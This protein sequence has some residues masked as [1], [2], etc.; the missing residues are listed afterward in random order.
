[1]HCN[2]QNVLYLH[3][4]L[5][6]T[7]CIYAVLVVQYAV[8]YSVLSTARRKTISTS[9]GRIEGSIYLSYFTL[10]YLYPCNRTQYKYSLYGGTSVLSKS[11]SVLIN[12]VPSSLVYRA[13]YK[14][15]VADLHTQSILILI[16][17]RQTDEA[18]VA[19]SYSILALLA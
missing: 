8:Q 3:G 1:M 7:V 9:D 4:N 12:I 10:G 15:V 14:Y 5:T 18:T 17:C 11:Y 19:Y 13:Q 16:T 2:V 6:C